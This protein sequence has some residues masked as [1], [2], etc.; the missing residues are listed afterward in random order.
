[1]QSVMRTVWLAAFS[2]A[3]SLTGALAATA[4]PGPAEPTS[5]W[6]RSSVPG[7][8]T[9]DLPQRA[10]PHAQT[11]RDSGARDFLRKA[12]HRETVDGTEIVVFAYFGVLTVPD[13]DGD[14][15][16]DVLVASA[17]GKNSTVTSSI[18]ARRGVDGK[19]I[20]RKTFDTLVFPVPAKVGPKAVQGFYLLSYG[21]VDAVAGWESTLTVTATDAKTTPLWTKTYD[22]VG[23][24]AILAD[25]YA[26]FPQ[27]SS[28]A[29]ITPDAA[30]DLLVVKAVDEYDVMSE[31]HAATAEVVSGADGSTGASIGPVVLQSGYSPPVAIDD[32]TGD[33][34]A[35]VFIGELNPQSSD[36]TAQLDTYRGTDGTR[37]WSVTDDYFEVWPYSVPDMTGDHRADLLVTPPMG[38]SRLLN[39]AT[40]KTVWTRSEDIAWP[41]GD[42]NRDGRG[43]LLMQGYGGDKESQ[44]LTLAVVGG[45][46][47]P[48]WTRT[49][50]MSHSGA[51]L[52]A[53]PVGDL[54]A[55]GVQD[56]LVAADF[57]NKAG[58][59]QHHYILDG[60]T[61]GLLLDGLPKTEEGAYAA[62]DGH[63]DD[64]I[65][66]A[67]VRDRP[68]IT[69]RRGENHRALWAWTGRAGTD[70]P[71][72]FGAELT[73]DRHA[74]VV[75]LDGDFE[76]D[77]TIS[78]L[79]GATGR[80]RWR[81]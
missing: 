9:A 80:L 79:D 62:I 34:L 60:R 67:L 66:A 43:E 41:V 1:M 37:V 17:N 24:S 13:I 28:V 22:G 77:M 38:G 11:V 4:N 71:Y 15:K 26:A 19:Q 74:D 81:G 55:D 35:D 61:G 65:D 72:A 45:S 57:A 31:E 12:V 46:N 59:G 30:E 7:A 56:V 52:R 64:L 5:A 44:K 18:T 54:Q 70:P 47:K 25:A 40:G 21:A 33:R 14:H 6:T 20:W 75:L 73:G 76:R 42:T 32:I 53:Y 3:V 50:S 69:A 36:Q 51:R 2:T 27:V 58:E 29:R 39:G 48:T 23:A 8:S 68:V 78:V 49:V 63:G 10:R 16:P